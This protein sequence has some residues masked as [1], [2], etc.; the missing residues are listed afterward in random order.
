MMNFGPDNTDYYWKK[1]HNV[2]NYLGGAR[3]SFPLVHEQLDTILRIINHFNPGI[4]SFLDLGCGDGFLGKVVFSEYQVEGTFLDCSEE[5]ISKAKQNTGGM[6]SFIV[7]DFGQKGWVSS[8]GENRSFDLIISGFAIHH[9]SDSEKIRLYKDVYQLLN[10]KGIFLNL[11]HVKSATEPLEEIF[12]D[13]FN[14]CL[15]EYH[16]GIGDNR[17][18]A[19]I[20]EHYH[21]PEH[22]ALNKLASTEDQCQ[23]LR[24]AGFKNVDCYLKIF[25][26]ALVGGTK[27]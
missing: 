21:D 8:L 19:E 12:Q 27:V 10:P 3:K 25:E 14:D 24:D 1:K 20:K 7:Q 4:R 15:L 5:M 16:L 11:E 22:Q 2:E 23:W 9:I 18:K 26:L 17:T 6:G 13:L